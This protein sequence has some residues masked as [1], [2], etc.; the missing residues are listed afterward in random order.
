MQIG[1]IRVEPGDLVLADGSGI[2]FLAAARAEEV[3]AA[4]ETIAAREALMKE[5]VLKGA[6]VVDV[7]GRDYE[8][9]LSR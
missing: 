1:R 2:V 9:M 6:S 7:M 4:A 5:A 8:T 3:I